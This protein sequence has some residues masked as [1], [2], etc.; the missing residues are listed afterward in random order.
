[1]EAVAVRRMDVE[2]LWTVAQLAAF[3]SVSKSWVY[4]SSASGTIPCVRIGAALRFVP[5]AIRSWLNGEQQHGN[6][7]RLPACR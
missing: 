6:V 2:P 4:Q 7:V 3:L 5:Q 1:M